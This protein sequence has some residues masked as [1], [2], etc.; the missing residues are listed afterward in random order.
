MASSNEKASSEQNPEQG[1]DNPP[2]WAN[3]LK[4]LYDDVVEEP[5]PDA[6]KDLLAQLDVADTTGDDAGNET[7]KKPPAGKGAGKGAGEGG[8]A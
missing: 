8:P 1:A 6:F 4:Q 3:G 5:L 2:A 7:G